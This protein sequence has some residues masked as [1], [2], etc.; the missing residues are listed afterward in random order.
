MATGA[1]WHSLNPSQHTRG[2][3][4]APSSSSPNSSCGSYLT[5]LQRSAASQHSSEQLHPLAYTVSTTSVIGRSS[6][7]PILHNVWCLQERGGT[8][9][10]AAQVTAERVTCDT[11]LAEC[12]STTLCSKAQDGHMLFTV[13]PM[14]SA[15]TEPS[16]G[17]WAALGSSPEHLKQVGLSGS[18]WATPGSRL[19]PQGE[20]L[21][22][23]H[24]HLQLA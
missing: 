7:V 23:L 18:Q 12:P 3:P 15:P 6:R 11:A 16:S 21:Q 9:S 20:H 10:C 17:L 19:I 13:H 8:G 14:A 4:D 2:S 22:D 5:Y 24:R 1:H